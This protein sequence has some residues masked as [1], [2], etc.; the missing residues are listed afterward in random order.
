MFIGYKYNLQFINEKLKNHEDFNFHLAIPCLQIDLTSQIVRITST[1]KVPN[2]MNLV[3]R[4]VSIYLKF[5]TFTPLASVKLLYSYW[6][7]CNVCY[8]WRMR[9]LSQFQKF[10]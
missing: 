8:R 1:L 5:P 4:N 3:K 7:L 6:D 10:C 9:V 2:N